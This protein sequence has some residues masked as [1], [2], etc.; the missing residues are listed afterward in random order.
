MPYGSRVRYFLIL[1][2][3]VLTN[4][5]NET[6][7]AVVD[8]DA[9]TRDATTATDARASTDA[10]VPPLERD[11]SCS[12]TAD[13]ND[14]VPAGL[15]EGL[16]PRCRAG[17][18]PRTAAFCCNATSLLAEQYHDRLQSGDWVC[19]GTDDGIEAYCGI[20]LRCVAGSCPCGYECCGTKILNG[21]LKATKCQ[22]IGTCKAPPPDLA[23]RRSEARL[24]CDATHP[25]SDGT[26][27][28]MRSCFGLAI[29]FCGPAITTEGWCGSPL[30]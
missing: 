13:W 14:V 18:C 19:T 21:D 1:I 24:L 4:C 17:A 6:P 30:Q 3:V 8:A 9:G 22:P 5:K 27:C 25:C 28:N 16:G 7:K 23:G 11:W 15:F 26:A 10:F 20:G 12:S 29:G 2:V